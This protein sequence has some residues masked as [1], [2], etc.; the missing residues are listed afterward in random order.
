V[1]LG[2]FSRARGIV[3]EAIASVPNLTT[4]FVSLIE[5]YLLY[6]DSTVKRLL[7]ERLVKAGLPAPP[8]GVGLVC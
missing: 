8:G 3:E 7:I 4:D 6:R 2:E 1:A 5:L